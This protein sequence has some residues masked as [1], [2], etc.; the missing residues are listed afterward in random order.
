MSPSL[1]DYK[2]PKVDLFSL[3]IVIYIIMTGH[4]PFHTSPA[5]Q[6]AERFAYGDRVF[7]LYQKG[8]FPNLA[9]VLLGRIIAGCCC[10]RRFKTAEEVVTALQAEMQ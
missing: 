9:D 2:S 3:G 1:E 5:P 4:Y 6:N 7:A 8:R 10:E